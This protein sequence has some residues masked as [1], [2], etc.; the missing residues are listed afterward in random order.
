MEEVCNRRD[1]LIVLCAGGLCETR[2]PY[3]TVARLAFGDLA[4]LEDVPP[5]GDEALRRLMAHLRAALLV[6][7]TVA[8]ATRSPGGATA[9]SV[10]SSAL[11][12]LRQIAAVERERL[13]Q[14]LHLVLPPIAKRM[15]SKGHRELIQEALRDLE[16]YGGPEAAKTIRNRGLTAGLA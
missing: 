10:F 1:A 8:G 15:F 6:E 13:V 16:R 2:H 14:H 7:P 11:L 9:S 4:A 12:A 3:A 5:V